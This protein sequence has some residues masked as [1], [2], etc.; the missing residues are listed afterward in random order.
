[1]TF[2][3]GDPTLDLVNTV[4]WR[5][6]PTRREDRLATG[7]ALSLWAGA[8]VGSRAPEWWSAAL[9]PVVR[10]REELAEALTAG[11]TPS[12]ALRSA[13]TAAMRHAELTSVLPPRWT[14]SVDRPRD[15]A[16]LLALHALRF[17]EDTDPARI[18]QCADDACGWLFL[19]RSRNNSRRWCASTDCGN[20][21]RV[22]KH[23]QRVRTAK[24]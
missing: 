20:R 8:L 22:R 12:S 23:T 15:L 6:D 21:N 11:G 18:R 16:D 1:M 5:L 2:L 7:E 24:R 13:L 19:D 10:L 14:V 17:F 9:S 4:A 3:A